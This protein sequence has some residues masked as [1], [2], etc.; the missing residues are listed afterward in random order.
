[1]R[2]TSAANVDISGDINAVNNIY[3]ASTIYHEGDVNT[4]MQF[5][6]NDQWRVVTGATEM[7]E[8]NNSYILAGANTV[9][10]VHTDTNQGAGTHTPNL[11]VYNSFVWT[12]TGN[13][14]LGNPST[15]ITGMSGVFVFIHSGAGRTVS[16]GNQYKTVGGAGLTLSGAAGAVDLVP[17]F[18][19]A[20]GIINLGTPQLAFA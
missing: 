10:K 15:E 14:T 13:I 3:L 7:L 5:H 4:Y 1:M 8:I 11:Y 20:G 12:L 18:V 2:I 19:R 6:A 9:G 17:Y 16:L